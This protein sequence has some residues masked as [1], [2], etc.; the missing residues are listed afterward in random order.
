MLLVIQVRLVLLEQL[1]LQA[2]SE[3]LVQLEIL[4]PQDHKVQSVQR[5]QQGLQGL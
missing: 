4:A 5:V 3:L 1:E 2:Q